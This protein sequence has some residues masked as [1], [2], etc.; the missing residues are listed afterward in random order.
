MQLG[1]GRERI[2]RPK[3]TKQNITAIRTTT[4]SIPATTTEYSYIAG[5]LVKVHCLQEEECLFLLL[6]GLSGVPWSFVPTLIFTSPAAHLRLT[7]HS[8]CSQILLTLRDRKKYSCLFFIL[9]TESALSILVCS[10]TLFSLSSFLLPRLYFLSSSPL[11][12]QRQ[13]LPPLPS[14]L[15]LS[16]SYLLHVP[17]L[18][19]FPTFFS[20]TLLIHTFVSITS[21]Q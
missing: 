9:Q 15:S 4:T 2:G 8:L 11:S 18:R 12:H 17:S 10:S 1:K 5:R 6:P 20:D 19:S 14:F 13:Q 16:T 3:Q 21:S 7:F